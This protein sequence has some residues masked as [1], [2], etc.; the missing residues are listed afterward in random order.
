MEYSN[1]LIHVVKS[2]LGANKHF[3][4]RKII[5]F[6]AIHS[7]SGDF[8]KFVLHSKNPNLWRHNKKSRGISWICAKLL[9]GFKTVKIGANE[10][11]IYLQSNR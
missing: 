1:S 3:L 11:K 4:R 8:R 7:T 10:K 9:G 2:L 6:A 5:D